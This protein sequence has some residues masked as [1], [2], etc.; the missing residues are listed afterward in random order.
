MNREEFEAA[1]ILLG[2][3]T[4]HDGLWRGLA[5]HIAWA[6]IRETDEA[7]SGFSVGVGCGGFGGWAMQIHDDPD[8]ALADIEAMCKHIRKTLETNREHIR[9]TLETTRETLET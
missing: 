4:T 5:H 8:A 1:L 3:T 2:F 6:R 7:A 9:E